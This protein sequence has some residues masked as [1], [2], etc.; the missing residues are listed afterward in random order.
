MKWE[1][2]SLQPRENMVKE[3]KLARDVEVGIL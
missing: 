2:T 1:N 3:F